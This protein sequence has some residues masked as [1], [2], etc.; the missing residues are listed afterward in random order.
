MLNVRVVPPNVDQRATPRIPAK[1]PVLVEGRDIYHKPIREETH[2]LLVNEAGALVAL[3]AEL[4]LEN[5]VRITN[6]ANANTAEC[7][8]AFRSAEPIQGRRS[9]GIALLG[10]PDNFWGLTKHA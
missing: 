1:V 4:E 6:Q 8:I 7:R 10:A 3:A 9:Y 2:T 5:R